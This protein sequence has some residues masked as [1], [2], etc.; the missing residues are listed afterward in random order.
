M[1]QYNEPSTNTAA[2]NTDVTVTLA[3]LHA[4]G[5]NVTDGARRTIKQISWSHSAD[6]ASASTLTIESPS[7]TV[8]WRVN[9]T[10]GGP[11]F[12]D[13]P[14]N[15]LPGA[16]GQEMVARLD[17]AAASNTIGMVNILEGND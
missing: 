11:G 12:F 13:F 9:I 8:L 17:L 4:D 3:A 2:V 1:T 10:K 6:P 14:N 7:G 5:Q 15:G 16:A